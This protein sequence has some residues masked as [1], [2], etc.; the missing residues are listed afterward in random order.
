MYLIYGHSNEVLLW[1]LIIS[2]DQCMFVNLWIRLA[3]SEPGYGN[4]CQVPCSINDVNYE[5]RSEIGT[6]PM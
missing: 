1:L 5:M 3:I 6:I 2:H 4:V